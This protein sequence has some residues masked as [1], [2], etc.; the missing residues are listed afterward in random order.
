VIALLRT[1][2]NAATKAGLGSSS[3]KGSIGMHTLRHFVATKLLTSGVDHLV[4]SRILGHDSI[5][6]T[7]N[8]YGHMEDSSR[9]SALALLA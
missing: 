2:Q 8:I 3:D 6:T 7:V 5:Q 4:V 9:K 1:L